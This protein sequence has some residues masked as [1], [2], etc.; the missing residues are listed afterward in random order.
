MQEVTAKDYATA[1]LEVDD[2]PELK[3]VK[4]LHK[5]LKTA[6]EDWIASFRDNGGVAGIYKVR[7]PWQVLEG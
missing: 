4:A 6:T 2:L 3:Q 7:T 5:A 1:L